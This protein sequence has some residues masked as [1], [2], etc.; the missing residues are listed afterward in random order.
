[1]GGKTREHV[2][3]PDFM[4]P[5]E[6]S[7]RMA[8]VRGRNTKPELRLRRYLREGGLVGYRVGLR[9]VPGAPDVAYTRWKVAVF[10]DGA[11]WHG[12]PSR[13]PERLSD[14][15]RNKIE[16][17]QQRDREVNTQLAASGWRVVRLWDFEVQKTP[18]DCVARVAIALA[19]AG[20]LAAG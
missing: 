9:N 11:F 7:A 6:R 5:A 17:N 14:A 20:R 18:A 12:H 10:V 13:H 16:R 15:W 1:M 4:T 19:E 3:V 2:R 8:L